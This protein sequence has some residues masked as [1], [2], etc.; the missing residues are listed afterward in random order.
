[1]TNIW[2]ERSYIS[3]FALC[4]AEAACRALEH[5]KLAADRRELRG[6]VL[7]LADVA[8]KQAQMAGREYLTP[9]TLERRL[10]A[11]EEKLKALRIL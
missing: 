4:A 7:A 11:I 6:L 5:A 10:A 1:M 8:R 9:K 2:I 3:D